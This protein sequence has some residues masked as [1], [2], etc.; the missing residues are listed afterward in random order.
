MQAY[1]LGGYFREALAHHERYHKLRDDLLNETSAQTLHTLRVRFEIEQAE[2]E[3]ELYRAK[4]A[5]LAAVNRE[6]ELL[7]ASLRQADREKSALLTRLEQQ[8][9]EDPLTGLYNRRYFDARLAEEFGRARRFAAPL[10]VV[11]CDIN[12]F[13]RVNDRFSHQLGDKVLVT[14]ATII[15]HHLRRIDT[16]ARYGG[17]EFMFLLPGTTAQGAA[18]SCEKIRCAIQVHP[19]ETLAPGLTVTVSTGFSDDTTLDP[20]HLLEEAGDKLYEAKRGGKNKVQG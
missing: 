16:V 9:C 15:S 4:N 17:E 5:E 3:R 18:V 20:A 10:S 2:R 11:F 13:K 1:K 6:L 7:T 14:V 8:A 19:W 12:N